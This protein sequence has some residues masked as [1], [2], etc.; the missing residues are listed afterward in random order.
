MCFLHSYVTLCLPY[1]DVLGRAVG[2]GWVDTFHAESALGHGMNQSCIDLNV[3]RQSFDDPRSRKQPI[4]TIRT[5]LN[6]R[7]M[8]ILSRDQLPCARRK[9]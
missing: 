8:E 3:Q 1:V 6:L 9:I 4:I 2:S 7:R 5:L